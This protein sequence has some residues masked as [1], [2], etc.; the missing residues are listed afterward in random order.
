MVSQNFCQI[1][2]LVFLNML[3]L[4]G[5]TE[6]TSCSRRD[7]GYENYYIN[8]VDNSELQ[9][10]K[11][12]TRSHEQCT[13]YCCS[14][15]DCSLIWIVQDACYTVKCRKDQCVPERAASGSQFAGSYVAFIERDQ[16]FARNGRISSS[17]SHSSSTGLSCSMNSY[18]NTCPEN[19]Q[20]TVDEVSLEYRCA[21]V[22][23]YFR[24]P[25]S[26]HC[27]GFREYLA[28]LLE[29][30]ADDESSSDINDYKYPFNSGHLND[31]KSGY[32][33]DHKSGH[34]N[35]H[36]NDQYADS[37]APPDADEDSYD[38]LP[39]DETQL[40]GHLQPCYSKEECKNPHQICISEED[41]PLGLCGCEDDYEL[42]FDTGLCMSATTITTS[43]PQ[44]S[45]N[46]TEPVPEIT[47]TKIPVTMPTVT[48]Q[49]K[50][51]AAATTFS[52]SKGGSGLPQVTK[53]PNP[54]TDKP[55]TQVKR[56]IANTPKPITPDK[57]NKIDGS[58][59]SGTIGS[60]NETLETEAPPAP[61]T[62]A[63][64]P[65]SP[66]TLPT[67]L[68]SVATGENKELTLPD[69]NSVNLFAAVIPVTQ[70][71]GEDYTYEW[72]LLPSSKFDE[73]KHAEMVGSHTQKLQLM[74][75]TPGE[76]NFQVE[77]TG[78]NSYGTDYINVTVH[79]P[80]RINTPPEAVIEP[81]SQE[82]T[83]PSKD[84]ILDGSHSSDDDGIA[85]YHWEE[86][87]G[88]IRKQKIRGD[89]STLTL[90]DLIPGLYII[91][92]TVTDTDG[93]V[94]STFANVTVIEETDYPP[95]ADAGPDKIVKLPMTS[96]ILYGNSST[97][98]HH[99]TSWEWS[100]ESGGLADMK[101]SG[102][103]TLQLTGL[104]EGNYV[105]MLKVEDVKEQKSSDRV[106]VIVQPVNNEAPT[107][108][109]G[110]DKEL[111]LTDEVTLSTTL[112]GSGSRDDQKIVTYQWKY[113]SGPST[114]I[115]NNG[116][117]AIAT[118]AGLQGGE[119]SF[120]LTVTDGQ[121]E[122]NSDDITVTVKKEVNQ[123]PVAHAGPDI[124][125]TLPNNYVELDG[126]E[127]AD[128]K[129]IVSYFWSRTPES[130][131]AGVVL[132]SSQRKAK[133]QLAYLV[134]GTYHFV[135]NVTDA[136]GIS[137]TDKVTVTVNQ[138]PKRLDL[139]EMTFGVEAT[140]F[141]EQNKLDLIRPLAVMLSVKDADILVQDIS[142]T[143]TGRLKIVFSVANETS[144]KAVPGPTVAKTLQNEQITSN[145]GLLKF[146][147]LSV[148][149]V[150]CQ[151]NCSNHGYCDPHQKKC[152]CE[153]FWMQNIFRVW[154]MDGESN[155]DWSILYVI[156]VSFVIAVA[157][158][159]VIWFIAWCCIRRRKRAKRRRRYNLLSEEMDTQETLEMLPKAN[160]G[161]VLDKLTD[162]TS[163]KYH[164]SH[165]GGGQGKQSSSI[166]ISESDEDTDEETTLFD[167]KKRKME[168]RQRSYTQ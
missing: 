9:Y 83:L 50:T 167:N 71:N 147:V 143:A 98:D 16:D 144:H 15:K 115:I 70:P 136:K 61:S 93:I 43:S 44:D 114:P 96:V 104:E 148:D 80:R 58:P 33:N 60:G 12:N 66:V 48:K 45:T 57:K 163:V 150:V 77:V 135:L 110:P 88:P 75:L 108:D 164:Q 165:G 78:V 25:S 6:G 56:P 67:K 24:D 160:N 121:G 73:E 103:D 22:A 63:A 49:H 17:P 76:Y 30:E 35:D 112:D 14:Q 126:S 23:G 72:I 120:K 26:G 161:N 42:D 47:T 151:L 86:V 113:I 27:L 81:D 90:N 105:F 132:N 55:I 2:I 99:I 145:T 149:T 158:G 52:P 36:V 134:A 118:V 123:P 8:I 11:Y 69:E 54:S 3:L 38:F 37:D 39:G 29:D 128:D 101:G 18:R 64:Q 95:K 137:N 127:S 34:F 155:C 116:Q 157:L 82:V 156:I 32:L 100:K 109:A 40:L 4:A 129:G 84:T 79:P 117:E 91:K 131:A 10:K 122:K 7:H 141:T 94:D 89:A 146:T 139:V 107:A 19:E 41:L 5:S 130:P 74:K 85:T 65:T 28:G 119:Y 87:E 140:K 154:F 162:D 153:S 133:L 68:L 21:C 159:A 53:Q 1:V 166:M 97:D 51:T 111:T 125:L 124:T 152:I 138:D 142:Q 20:C 106:T 59:T 31:H 102:T 46:A 168:N 13:Q 62:A 92:L